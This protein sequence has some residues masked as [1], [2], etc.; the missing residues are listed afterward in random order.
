MS[1]AKMQ[2]DGSR[3]STFAILLGGISSLTLSIYQ[4]VYHH[5]FYLYSASVSRAVRNSIPCTSAIHS[6]WRSYLNLVEKKERRYFP[7]RELILTFA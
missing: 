5:L 4:C 7:I 3:V 2:A 6:R 1:I